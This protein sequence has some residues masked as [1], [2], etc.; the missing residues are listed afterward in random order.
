[1]TKDGKPETPWEVIR[2][3]IIESFPMDIPVGPFLTCTRNVS[4]GRIADSL[5]SFFEKHGIVLLYGADAADWLHD[6]EARAARECPN[7]YNDTGFCLPSQL[8]PGI[9]NWC[10]IPFEEQ[11]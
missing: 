3:W 6:K 5:I 2:E 1:M 11:T 10:Q 9:C 7:E 4:A 8:A